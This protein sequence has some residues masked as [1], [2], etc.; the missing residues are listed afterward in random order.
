M[1]VAVTE[2]VDEAQRARFVTAVQLLH[3][4]SAVA[5][6]LGISTDTVRKMM[7]GKK[8]VPEGIWVELRIEM[9]RQAVAIA[10]LVESLGLKK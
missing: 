9:I 5:D 3:G 2:P 8:S 7:R 10:A 4:A 6:L 1:S